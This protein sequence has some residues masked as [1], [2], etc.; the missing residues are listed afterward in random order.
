M[1]TLRLHG[2]ILNDGFFFHQPVMIRKTFVI[3]NLSQFYP[4][5][6][7]NKE[8]R[9]FASTRDKV[10]ALLGKLYVIMLLVDGKQQWCISFG[11]HFLVVLQVVVLGFLPDYLYA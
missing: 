10:N 1:D 11:H 2:V 6:R 5:I 8:S 7:Q 9:I 4:N 3:L